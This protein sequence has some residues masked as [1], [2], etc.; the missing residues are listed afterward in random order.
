M[1]ILASPPGTEANDR[2]TP[3]AADN[4]PELK[5]GKN[6]ESPFDIFPFSGLY[7]DEG[8]SRPIPPV[9]LAVP[10]HYGDVPGVADG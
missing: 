8:S 3:K 10:I 9:R 6:F 5:A 7:I 2:D 4:A 1:V